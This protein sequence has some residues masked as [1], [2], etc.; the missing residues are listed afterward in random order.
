MEQLKDF[1]ELRK[2]I[3]K[4]LWMYDEW[5]DNLQLQTRIEIVV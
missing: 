2:C 1:E 5:D 4:I 3:E